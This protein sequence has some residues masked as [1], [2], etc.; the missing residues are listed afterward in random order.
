VSAESQ[1]LARRAGMP[2]G[3]AAASVALVEGR[4]VI[5]PRTGRA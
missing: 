5:V 4:P 3:V 1:L 2:I